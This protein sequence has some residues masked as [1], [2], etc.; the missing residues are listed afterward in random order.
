M[1]N[2]KVTI[3]LK[4]IGFVRNGVNPPKMQGW[5]DI[6]SEIVV[7]PTL[8]GAL[9]SLELFSHVIILYWMDKST[10][11]ALETKIHPKHNPEFPLVGLFATRAPIR[12]NPI[13]NTTVKL[14]E[15]RGNIL[16]VQG[17]DAYDGTP[18]LDIKPYIPGNDCV[19]GVTVPDWI[20][21][22]Q[23]LPF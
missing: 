20:S 12:P 19:E 17:L 21:E 9:D 14:L 4:A 11:Q 16:K 3:S 10:S 15:H 6:I 23:K 1:N 8:E 2:Q 13:A 22:I 18:V 5:K 7:D